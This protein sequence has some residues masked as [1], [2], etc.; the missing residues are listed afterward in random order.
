MTARE[1]L[2]SPPGLTSAEADSRRRRDGPNVLP[3]APPP[4]AWRVLAGQLFH[5][6][7]IMLWGAA[8]LA[9]LAGMP[10]LA[11]AIVVIVVLNGLFAFAQEHRAE[12]AAE[13]LRD[14]L[15]RVATVIRDGRPHEIDARDLVV[16]DLVLL[17]AGDRISA[18]LTSRQADVLSVDTSMLT[19]ESVPLAVD[20]GD[21]LQ[22][23]TFVVEGE[24]RAVVTA[25]RQPDP[26]RE[27]RPSHPGRSSPAEP[28]RP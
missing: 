17:E 5:F 25:D 2:G 1:G 21:A 19:G 13:R 27:Y 11:V 18:D 3:S 14:L 22:A 20:V 28:A 26:P 9:F 16:G 23:G 7:A 6:F 15:P 12:R 10:Q 24:A 8:G 4:P